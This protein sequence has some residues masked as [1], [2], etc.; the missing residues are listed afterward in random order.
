[1]RNKGKAQRRRSRRPAEGQATPIPAIE[2]RTAMDIA[3]ER[4]AGLA[5]KAEARAREVLDSTGAAQSAEQPE[6]WLANTLLGDADKLRGLAK[7]MDD[8]G[9]DFLL[10]K[11]VR[12]NL[13]ALREVM[14]DKLVKRGEKQLADSRR[15]AEATHGELA[16][17]KRKAEEMYNRRL[18]AARGTLG[19]LDEEVGAACGRNE[20]WARGIRLGIGKGKYNRRNTK[21]Q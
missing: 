21:K 4:C 13:E 11:R 19:Q 20:R 2:G 12:E 15:G 1:M 17:Q 3:R 16:T 5:T 8:S 10:E 7:E 14:R 6:V 18:P 9:G